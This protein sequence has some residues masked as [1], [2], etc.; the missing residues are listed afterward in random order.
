MTAQ[1]DYTA[2]LHDEIDSE[3]MSNKLDQIQTNIYTNE[4]LG[5]GH[6]QFNPIEGVVTED[7]LYRIEFLIP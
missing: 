7:H 6:S 3:V 5:A 1:A 2:S 4:P